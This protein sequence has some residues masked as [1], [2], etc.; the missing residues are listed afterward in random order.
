MW[1]Y[2]AVRWH[3]PAPNPPSTTNQDSKLQAP[4]LTF[5]LNSLISLAFAPRN[6][7]R[8][9]CP[10]AK[11]EQ[12]FGRI[13]VTSTL[14][15][16]DCTGLSKNAHT[17][18]R[19]VGTSGENLFCRIRHVFRFLFRR[20][21]SDPSGSTSY[22]LTGP[23]R[24]IGPLYS[25]RRLVLRS[26]LVAHFPANFR[27][28]SEFSS[29]PRIKL[30]RDRQILGLLIRANTRSGPETQHAIHFPAIV[31]LI[32]QGVLHFI[33]IARKCGHGHFFVEVGH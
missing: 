2:P 30:S 32:L 27:C 17:A 20:R 29:R 3:L 24:I 1:S 21:R 5:S 22:C 6:R 10:A 19:N 7:I 31:S 25:R 28:D 4:T 26:R 14:A 23:P 13:K 9:V 12:N 18:K 15:N 16:Q 11:S 33:Y 8:A